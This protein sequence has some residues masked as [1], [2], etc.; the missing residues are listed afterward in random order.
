MS[1]DYIEVTVRQ[2]IPAARGLRDLPGRIANAAP[3]GSI[4]SPFCI[5]RAM[6]Y[7]NI[8][9]STVRYSELAPDWFRDS[10]L[11]SYGQHRA[12]HL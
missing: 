11:M 7:F 5:F 6:V 2:K 1:I 10:G 9:V 4:Y 3:V 12:L 8:L